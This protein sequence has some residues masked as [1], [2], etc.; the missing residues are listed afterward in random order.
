MIDDLKT[1]VKW[2]IYLTMKMNLVSTTGFVEYRQMN[3]K[4]DNSEILRCFDTD[5]II[6]EFFESLVQRH[7]I[8]LEQSMKGSN[9]VFDRTINEG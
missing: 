9:F 4:S 8:G 5:E 7:Q 6:E 1:S 2:K 3:S